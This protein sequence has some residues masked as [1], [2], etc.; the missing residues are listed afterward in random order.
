MSACGLPKELLL[1]KPWQYRHVYA[2][3]RRLRGRNFTLIWVANDC[4]ESRLGISVHGFKSAVR[5]NRVKRLIREFFRRNRPFFQEALCARAAVAGADM[6]FAVRRE[7]DCT[8][9]QFAE[10]VQRLLR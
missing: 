7:F 9:N 5:R 3:G 4:G 2:N 6:V 10:E 8:S 1:R